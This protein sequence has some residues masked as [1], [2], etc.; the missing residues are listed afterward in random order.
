MLGSSVVPFPEGAAVCARPAPQRPSSSEAELERRRV[1][2]TENAIVLI[3]KS[4]AEFRTST[5]SKQA[6]AVEATG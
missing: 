2:F 6:L 1:P 5:N 4:A 3:L